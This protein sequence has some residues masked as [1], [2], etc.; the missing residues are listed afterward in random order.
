MENRS[1]IKMVAFDADDT[2]WPCQDYFEQTEERYLDIMQKYAPRKEVKAALFER[3]CQNMGLLGY[4]GKAFTISMIENAIQ[5]S[6]N[7]VTTNDINSIIKAGRDLLDMPVKPLDGVETTLEVLKEK[8][9]FKMV[10]FT[11]GDAQEQE[12]KIEKSTMEQW[13]DLTVTVADKTT[14]EFADLCQRLNVMPKD[15][16]MVGNSFKS[17]IMPAI[18]IGAKA[19]FIPYH[20]QWE[21]EQAEEV[22]HERIVKLTSFSQLPEV[23]L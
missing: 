12:R 3:E 17:D 16:V 9:S 20:K 11:K 22:N 21:M 10:L 7:R 13:F 23:L 6:N 1:E 18:E 2:L 8:A 15:M 19:V 14:R 5:V 4:G